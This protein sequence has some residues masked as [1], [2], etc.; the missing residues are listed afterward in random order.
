MSSENDSTLPTRHAKGTLFQSDV[1]LQIYI[2]TYISYYSHATCLSHNHAE[3]VY[4]HVTLLSYNHA[5]NSYNHV[6][7]LSHN[8]ADIQGEHVAASHRRVLM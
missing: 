1:I 2:L 4:N 6:T 3:N 7:L 5:E 8:H